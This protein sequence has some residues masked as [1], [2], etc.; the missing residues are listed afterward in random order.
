MMVKRIIINFP[1]NLGD[2]IIGLPVLDRL[3]SNYPQA[4]ISAITSPKT[5]DFFIRNTF[6][7]EVILFD[8]S[9]KLGTKIKFCLY[10]RGK[11]DLIADLKNSFLPIALGIRKRTPFIRRFSNKVHIED[12]YLSLIS[13]V[14]PKE[15]SEKSSFI[16]QDSEKDKWNYL[17]TK[18]AIFIAC[19]S[20]SS[21]KQYPYTHLKEVVS[22]FQNKQNII[23][24]GQE[25]DRGFYRDILKQRCVIDLVGKT[26]I[27]DVFYLLKKYASLLLGVDSS[28]THMANYLDLPV[29]CLFGPTSHERSFPRSKHSIVLRREELGC[30][31]CEMA[32]CEHDIECM[33]IAPQEVIEAINKI[34][35]NA[36]TK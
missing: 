19:S 12:K 2:A 28:I 30:S 21:I 5:R 31:P 23:I 35:K 17:E 9:W 24:L 18:R 22:F 10:L 20:L 16:L 3:R 36:K 26:D 25:Q 32:Q 7:D 34:L 6:I 14:A 13:A 1:T 11:Y 15:A 27:N 4:K 29:V 8:K 33:K